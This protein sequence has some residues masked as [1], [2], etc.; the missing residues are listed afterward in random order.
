MLD[1]N[2]LVKERNA[3]IL[4]SQSPLKFIKGCFVQ[5]ISVCAC[6]S[7]LMCFQDG[8]NAVIIRLSE[9]LMDY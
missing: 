3:L 5:V 4:A 1:I 6:R 2:L 8:V 9:R 7:A